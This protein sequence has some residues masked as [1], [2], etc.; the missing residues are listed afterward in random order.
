MTI[1]RTT[2]A[3]ALSTVLGA[4]AFAAT[5]PN[6]KPTP[7]NMSTTL[8]SA[9]TT[10]VATPSASTQ[11][12]APLN[13]KTAEALL[14][15]LSHNQV[16]IVQAF[17]SLGNLQGFVVKPKNG[18]GAPSL[19]Y[20]D[21]NGQY[22]VVGAIL[23]PEGVNQSEA[24]TQKYI[25]AGS[26]KDALADSPSTTWIQDGNPN[27]KH[28]AYVV[29][30]P[31]CIYCHKLYQLTRPAVKSGDLQLRWIWVGFLRDSSPGIAKAM[32]AAKDPAAAMAQNEDQFNES[33]E[34][35]GLP[36]LDNASAEVDAKY[37]KNMAFLNK[38]QF[39]GTPVLIYQNTDGTPMSL[40]GISPDDLDKTI[41]TMGQLPK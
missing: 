40:Y 12:A 21:A 24:D 14:N 28:S 37:A 11:A 31:N 1:S 41:N 30:D 33:Q 10:Q 13:T 19:V 35:G 15:K 23:T 29:A 16:T 34:A 22:A 3:I 6:A 9:T 5:T 8:A 18:Q 32:L 36:P 26:A 20:V 2:L 38:Y 7:T 17:P 27:A 25:N 39:P 4:T